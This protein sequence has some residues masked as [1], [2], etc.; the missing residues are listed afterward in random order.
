MKKQ[1]QNYKILLKKISEFD[2]R[3]IAV[4]LNILDSN[5]VIDKVEVKEISADLLNVLIT[6]KCGQTFNKKLVKNMPLLF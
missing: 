5:L 4:N 3:T 6:S 2:A 1:Q